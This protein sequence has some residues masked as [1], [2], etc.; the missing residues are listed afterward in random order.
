MSRM[1]QTPLCFMRFNGALELIDFTLQEHLQ[2]VGGFGG[3]D[4]LY[5]R[6]DLWRQLFHGLGQVGGERFLKHL[7]QGPSKHVVEVL[8][9]GALRRQEA[10]SPLGNDCRQF[11]RR[12]ILGILWRVLGFGGGA[13]TLS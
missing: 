5:Q 1:A 11:R 10:G 7:Q 3:N 2:Q 12:V 8:L 13:I 9:R 6:Q 4:F